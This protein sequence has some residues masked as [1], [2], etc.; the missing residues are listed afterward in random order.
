MLGG[1]L[2]WAWSLALPGA[3]AGLCALLGAGAVLAATTQGPVSSVVLLMEMTGG[4]RSFILP[5][6]V[7]VGTATLVSRTIEPRSIYDARLSDEEIAARMRTRDQ[8]LPATK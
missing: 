7:A 3:Q 8:P 1:V 2:G 5:L 4:D 6:L